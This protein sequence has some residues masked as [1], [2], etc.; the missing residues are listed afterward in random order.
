[1]TVVTQFITSDGT[2]NG[3]IV[4]IRRK[5]VQNGKV[6]E[7]PNVTI[8][9]KQY[10]SITDG[11]CDAAKTWMDDVKDYEKKGGMKQM[12][13][14]LKRG[15]TLVMSIWDDHDAHMLWLDSNYP[16]NK[17]ASSPGV[18]RGTC[19]TSSGDPNDVE[20]NSPNSSVTY[21]DIRWGDLDTTYGN[22]WAA[23]AEFV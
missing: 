19:S 21:S 16:T 18:A 8:N 9:G 2:E 6:I 20:N 22:S 7:T 1:M 3:D 14:A 12:G 10:N 15:M 17:P 23:A 13:G 11:F 4:E 5:Y